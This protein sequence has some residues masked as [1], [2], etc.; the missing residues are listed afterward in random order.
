MPTTRL[1]MLAIQQPESDIILLQEVTHTDF[2]PI[3][4]YKKYTNVGMTG[5]DTAIL[6]RENLRLTHIT[7]CLLIGAGQRSIAE[8]GVPQRG[9]RRLL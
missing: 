6:T 4:G 3:R 2:D 5:R 8:S 1:G 7:I 9:G